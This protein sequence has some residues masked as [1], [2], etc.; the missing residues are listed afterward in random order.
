[1]G[2]LTVSLTFIGVLECHHE[3][4]EG[5]HPHNTGQ[6]ELRSELDSQQLCH[7]DLITMPKSFLHRQQKFYPHSIVKWLKLQVQLLVSL[8]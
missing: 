2:R 4:S 6:K 5:C 1:M 7:V 8:Q 3:T